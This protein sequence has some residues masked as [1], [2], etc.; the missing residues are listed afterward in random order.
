M[1]P[2][3]RGLRLVQ[4]RRIEV[5]RFDQPMEKTPVMLGT[6]YISVTILYLS[7]WAGSL[8][9]QT[10]TPAPSRTSPF[11]AR[12][13]GYQLTEEMIQQAL[14]YGQVLAGADFSPSDAGALRSELIAYFPKETAKQMGAYESVAKIVRQLVGRGRKPSWLDLALIRYQAWQW[15]GE[16]SQDFRDFQDV[17]FGR[18]VLKYNP[19][20]V[21][22]GGMIVTKADVDCL[23]YSNTLV[24]QAA[25]V[26]PPT[27]TDKDRLIRTLPSQFGSLSKV[28]Q[29]AL[30]R[31]ELR[32]VP[33]NDGYT[34]T[35]KTRAA[36]IADIKRN[37]HS[38]ADVPPV[39]R[40]VENDTQHDGKYW[41]SYLNEGFCCCSPSAAFC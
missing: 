21:N 13:A 8:A 12:S 27:E 34:G 6:K 25:G 15:Y 4:Q 37:V 1:H 2:T 31:A 39:A 40:Q 16:N 5:D 11:V 17:P 23:F 14:L 9:G 22:S 18:M 41:Q 29:E 3:K 28:Q 36:M 7:V 24:A 33:V 10:R 35:I 26:G 32:V 38:S 20:L 30:R 19:V